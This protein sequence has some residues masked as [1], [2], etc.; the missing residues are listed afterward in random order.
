MK[1]QRTRGRF[2]IH[3]NKTLRRL[4]YNCQT[5]EAQCDEFMRQV[6]MKALQ[7][8][9]YVVSYSPKKGRY[10]YDWQEKDRLKQTLKRPLCKLCKQLIRRDMDSYMKTKEEE[11]VKEV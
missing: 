3:T 11:A 7:G 5:T 4:S 9:D 1:G 2:G 6:E 10:Y 8:D